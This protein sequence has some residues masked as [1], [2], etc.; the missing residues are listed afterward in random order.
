MAELRLH[1]NLV[2]GSRQ[3]FALDPASSIEAGDGWF[4]GAGSSSH[5]TISNAAFRTDDGLAGGE[6]VERAAAFFGERDRGFSVWVRGEEPEDA[7]L[8][9]AAGEAGFEFVYAMPEMVLSGPVEA[10]ALPPNAELRRV[11]SGEQAAQFWAV[12]KASYASLG[13]PPEVFAG[14]TNHDGLM[15]D[16]VATFVATIDGGIYWVGS[17]EHARGKGLGRAVTTA[18][19]NAGFEMGADIASLQASPF[20]KPI[21][22][23][24][25]YQTLYDY[26]L[27]M[28]RPPGPAD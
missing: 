11:E 18:A 14:Y 25:G 27:L 6:L 23:D 4:F 24:M 3:F 10:P 20:G 12:A 21:Y 22:E 8:A 16:G 15:A 7:D 26:R 2:D 19:T 28:S 13:F 5:P 1:L 9:A 17:L